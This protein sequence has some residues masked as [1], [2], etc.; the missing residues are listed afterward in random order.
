M[1]KLEN[2]EIQMNPCVAAHPNYRQ[3]LFHACPSLLRIDN[4][5]RDGK[6]ADRLVI[7]I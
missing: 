6:V 5:M 1:P 2:L 4:V 3:E 7:Y